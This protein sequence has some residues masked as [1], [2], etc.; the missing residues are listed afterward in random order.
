MLAAV[1]NTQPGRSNPSWQSR[2][3]TLL[4]IDKATYQ[5]ENIFSGRNDPLGKIID[6]G[7]LVHH[8]R[9]DLNKSPAA[10]RWPVPWR[11]NIA[12]DLPGSTGV[13][14]L[15]QAPSGSMRSGM[16]FGAQAKINCLSRSVYEGR[17]LYKERD[18]C[19]RFRRKSTT[20]AP[21]GQPR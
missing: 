7:A 3:L 18:H 13:I 9:D 10:Y 8:R 21:P 1:S 17:K 2:L 6:R 16:V 5:Q 4:T 19:C 11:A 14:C 20:R 15:F 12:I